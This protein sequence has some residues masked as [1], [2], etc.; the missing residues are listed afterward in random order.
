MFA[1]HTMGAYVNVWP[2]PY[3]LQSHPKAA[4]LLFLSFTVFLFHFMVE[5]N[6]LFYSPGHRTTRNT[7]LCFFICHLTVLPPNNLKDLATCHLLLP[8]PGTGSL[9][10][11]PDVTAGDGLG[12]AFP[13]TS[14]QNQGPCSC[15]S[16]MVGLE[17]QLK[18]QQKA[19]AVLCQY[20]G[21]EAGANWFL[22]WKSHFP[23]ISLFKISVNVQCPQ[24]YIRLQRSLSQV[25]KSKA[26]NKTG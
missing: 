5:G 23:T 16:H 15:T 12:A 14:C 1:A 7:H 9:L 21:N 3:S 22:L 26:V 10:P 4:W 17:L 13:S 8:L 18:S 25:V 2:Y 24:V 20:F 11:F 19:S 6:S